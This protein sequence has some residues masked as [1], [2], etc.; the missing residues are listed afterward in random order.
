MYDWSRFNSLPRGYEW[1]R[2]ELGAQRVTAS[3]L[4]D[5]SL[6][7][8]DIGTIRRMGLALEREGVQE[9]LLQKLRRALKPSTGLIPWIPSK[10]KRGTVNR[11]W[12]V[13]VNDAE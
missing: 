1:I 5:V 4:V 2:R 7:Y 12:G 9:S 10:P 3:E 11:A 8:G 6:R 13:V